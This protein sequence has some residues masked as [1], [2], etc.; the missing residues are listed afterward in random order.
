MLRTTIATTSPRSFVFYVVADVGFPGTHDSHRPLA[1]TYRQGHGPGPCRNGSRSAQRVHHV[2]QDC[3]RIISVLTEPANRV[4]LE[5]ELALAVAWYRGGHHSEPDRVEIPD[6]PQPGYDFSPWKSNWKEKPGKPDMPELPWAPGIREFPFVSSCLRLALNRDGTYGT[7]LGDVQEQALGTVFR[8][9]KLE[10]GIVVIDISDLDNVRYGIIGLKINYIANIDL[11]A[12][13]SGWDYIE[14][15]VPDQELV[16]KL[17]E[18]RSRSPLCG[19]GYM[20]KHGRYNWK[21]AIKRLKKQPVAE[22][23]ALNSRRYLAAT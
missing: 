12:N 3:A 16:I 4:A 22:Q 8:G 2:L 6:A 23:S 21:D 15:W 11:T 17:E 7:R 5:A 18:S 9:D 20:N 13:P 1:V 19:T 10:Y 14:S